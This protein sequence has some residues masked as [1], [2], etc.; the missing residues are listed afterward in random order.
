[1]VNEEILKLCKE[2]G[3]FLDKEVFKLVFD[4]DKNKVFE[5]IEK[6]SELKIKERIVTRKVC[7][8]YIDKF[9]DLF[10]DKN[11]VRERV[12]LLSPPIF[13]SKKISVADFAGHFQVRY[14]MIKKILEAKNFENLSSIRRIGVNNGVW[15]IIAAVLNKKMTKNKN[16]LIEVEDLTGN[17]IVLMNRENSELFARAKELLLDDIVAFK[18]SGSNKMLFA[19][20]IIYPDTALDKKKYSNFDE[21]IAFSG[22]FHIGSKMFLEKKLLRFVGWLNGEI[23]DNRQKLIAKKVKYLFL[24]GDNIDGVGIYPGQDKFLN[25]KSCREQ[26]QKIEEILRKIRKDIQI[27]MCPG[28]HDAVW[29]GEPQLIIPEKWAPGLYQMKN[30]CLVSNPALIEVRGGFKI[31][32]YHGASINRFISEMSVIRA[33]Y[34]H[35]SP[36]RIVK[37]ML[38]RRHLAPI[39]GLMDYIP[40]IEKDSM[41][42][43]IVP[44]IIATADQHRAEIDNYNNILMIAS[45]CWQSTTPFEDKVGNIPEPCRVPLFNLKTRETKIID[46]SGDNEIKCAPN[47][48][49]YTGL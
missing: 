25:I 32:I 35:K 2:K 43:D 37:E 7:N 1:M 21:Y 39:H 23:G 12:R 40:C 8:K 45:S 44:D 22:D 15:I 10:N 31:L 38:K 42:I 24:T 3:F 20:D 34:G 19:S 13:F 33:K 46:F 48:H 4:L 49:D 28:Q 5:I 30:L 36:T 14:E 41:V 47:R 9:E 26:Y 6:L 29:V 17:S 16:L 11:L 27:V 18:V